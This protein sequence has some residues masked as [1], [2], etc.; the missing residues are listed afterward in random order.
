MANPQPTDA[1]LRVAHSIN[2]AIMLRDFSKRQR[3]I[4]DLI[5]R[6]SW[7]CGKKTA[8]IPR[9]RDF[10]VIGIKETHISTALAWL[11]ESKIIS[12]NST[13][14]AF[15]K[16]FDQWQVSRVSP[17]TPE[18]LTELVRKN[19]NN[20]RELT[21]TVSENLLKGEVSTYHNSKFPTPNLASPKESIKEN[22]YKGNNKSINTD[23]TTTP[24]PNS[25]RGEV[26][27]AT[28]GANQVEEHS[29][30][31]SLD[32]RLPDIEPIPTDKI[33]YIP[34]KPDV[35]LRNFGEETEQDK[36]RGKREFVTVGDVLAKAGEKK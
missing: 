24:A 32:P 34:N 13:E 30:I 36:G 15:N 21:K 1:H 3:K 9:Q 26:H 12:I 25:G 16:D 14:Y 33:K 31:R 20:N 11:V 27:R 8:Y 10:E 23:K 2:E 22:I 6:L 35:L 7:G 5:L 19:L 29:R 18:K 4:L 28:T 17:Y